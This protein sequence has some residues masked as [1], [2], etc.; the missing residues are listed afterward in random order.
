M[1]RPSE[2]ELYE[3]I[4]TSCACFNFR[5]AAK[6]VTQFYD[7][8]L[9]PVDLTSSQFVVLVGCTLLGRTSMAP[10]AEVLD[11]DRSTLTRNVRPLLERKLI[12][13]VDSVAD[14]RRREVE[15][16]PA[17]KRTLE[18][19]VPLWKKAQTRVEKVYGLS[20]WSSML[21]DLDKTGSLRRRKKGN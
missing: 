13:Q 15:L 19:A 9:E 6:A 18:K 21:R 7:G 12:R 14:R 16:T 3:R 1:T 17:G 20:R 8:I 5:K 10:L 4:A 11:Q 2:T